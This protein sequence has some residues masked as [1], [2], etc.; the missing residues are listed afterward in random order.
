MKGEFNLNG[1]SL[2]QNGAFMILSDTIKT[3]N[4]FVTVTCTF[5]EIQLMTYT[6]RYVDIM[7]CILLSLG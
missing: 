7:W 5:K 1:Y 3:G 4:N 6:Y 2:W